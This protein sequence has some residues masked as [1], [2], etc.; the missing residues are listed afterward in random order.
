MSAVAEREIA[1]D[2]SE[3]YYL[4]E[5]WLVEAQ[6][7]KDGEPAVRCKIV[8][9]GKAGKVRHVHLVRYLEKRGERTS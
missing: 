5:H 4:G 3:W 6:E 7:T 9:K 8:S 1:P 2:G